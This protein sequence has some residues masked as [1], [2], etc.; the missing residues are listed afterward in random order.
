MVTGHLV[1]GVL[2]RQMEYDADRRQA[3]MA[4]SDSFVAAF[5]RIRLLGSAVL[6]AQRGFAQ[7]YREGRLA[8]NL[9]RLFADHL[10]Q[11]P[12]ESHALLGTQ[13]DGKLRKWFSSHPDDNDRIAAVQSLAAP[14]A[15][16]SRLPA[17]AVF[18]NF[19]AACKNVTWDLYCAL[20]RRLVAPAT[21]TPTADLIARQSQRR[22]ADN[23]RDRFFLGGFSALRP[24]RLPA[25]DASSG[26]SS[27]RWEQEIVE[28]RRIM[29]E[30]QDQYRAA[31]KALDLVDRRLLEA[32]RAKSVFVAQVRLRRD[33]FHEPPASS[34]A[35]TQQRDRALTEAARL[36][37]TMEVFEN[38]AGRRMIA[39]LNMLKVP[40]VAPRLPDA[41][42]WRRESR[43]LLAVVAPA[44][45]QTASILELRDYHAMLGAL[46]GHLRGH[47]RHEPLIREV[48]DCAVRVGER[49]AA[50][51]SFFDRVE[52]P[53]EHAGGRIVTSQFLVR[54]I[55]PPEH[56][57][58]L[59]AA[60]DE[61]L[62][63]LVSLYVRSISRLCEIA[64]AVETALGH[65]PLAV[66]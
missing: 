8:D 6:H 64:E 2:L 35:A 13:T 57:G 42:L 4:G 7:H 40:S 49:A 55:P 22:A 66:K 61:L 36:S 53:F 23:A 37:N 65:Q 11:M 20:F 56:V 18:S 1:A 51:R 29:D 54:A 24:M 45:V 21:L 41:E 34:A 19:E 10:A 48:I 14:G 39:C 5:R 17:S 52:Y 60:V 32:R 30:H 25:Q 9:P 43:K 27:Q 47:E 44:T 28:A 16:Q 31:L 33:L 12:D 62:R 3:Y 59:W 50:V 26:S 46:L 38:A 15:F 63:N 58:E